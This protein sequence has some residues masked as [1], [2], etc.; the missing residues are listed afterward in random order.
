MGETLVAEIFP[1]VGDPTREAVRRTVAGAG[2]EERR[3][4]TSNPSSISSG[5][6]RTTSRIEAWRP[7]CP[8]G[9]KTSALHGPVAGAG[10]VGSGYRG[11]GTEAGDGRGA[12]RVGSAGV[13]RRER[14]R[15]DRGEDPPRV[16]G[17]SR[18]GAGAAWRPWRP[19]Q[20]TVSGT[21]ERR[22]VAGDP[23][24]TSAQRP[25]GEGALQDGRTPHSQG[26]SAATG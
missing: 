14:E 5:K 26:N 9:R 7:Y 19:L 17:E 18:G 8:G 12:G 11:E 20:L 23:G 13:Q 6:L 24:P 2:A 16:F 10:P 22:Q 4:S 25:V 3:S 1:R 15:E 21:Q